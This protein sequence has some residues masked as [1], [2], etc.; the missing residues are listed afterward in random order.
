MNADN[1]ITEFFNVHPTT[2]PQ[3]REMQESLKKYVAP[4][5]DFLA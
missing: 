5:I 4:I 1:I 2:E 3:Y